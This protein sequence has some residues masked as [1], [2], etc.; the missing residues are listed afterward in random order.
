MAD[1]HT[2]H[3]ATLFFEAR[4]AVE[5][6]VMAIDKLKVLPDALPIADQLS[7]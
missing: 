3:V 6:V 7:Q 5:V 2:A 1:D 4:L